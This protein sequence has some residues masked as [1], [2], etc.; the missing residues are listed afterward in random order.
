MDVGR[1]GGVLFLSLQET[2][3][4]NP[5]LGSVPLVMWRSSHPSQHAGAM[6]LCAK[7]RNRLYA[8]PTIVPMMG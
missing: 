7:R 1:Y 5:I 8:R 3:T 6:I 4:F 2:Q